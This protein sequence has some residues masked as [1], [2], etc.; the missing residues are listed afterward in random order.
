VCLTQ[1]YSTQSM[2]SVV[3]TAATAVASLSPNVS[4]TVP[5][6]RSNMKALANGNI[7]WHCVRYSSMVSCV[8]CPKSPLRSDSSTW[9]QFCTQSSIH[10][11]YQWLA[12]VLCTYLY[13][14]HHLSFCHIIISLNSWEAINNTE[15]E[16]MTELATCP[17]FEH[18]RHK[19]II[20][21][22]W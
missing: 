22:E 11:A 3:S 21:K 18:F 4:S 20:N 2:Q 9:A 14:A 15:T 7:V 19:N 8:T 5:F 12:F 13:C 16:I 17:M 10:S 6:G 1:Y